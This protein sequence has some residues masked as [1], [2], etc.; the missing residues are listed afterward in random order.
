MLQSW[1]GFVEGTNGPERHDTG[2]GADDAHKDIG[3]A[4]YGDS[5]A[6]RDWYLSYD[7]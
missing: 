7:Q 1:E 6:P 5:V 4:R 3:D 2:T